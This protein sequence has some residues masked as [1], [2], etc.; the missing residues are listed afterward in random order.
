MEH[1]AISLKAKLASTLVIVPFF[2]YTIL[3]TSIPTL[4]GYL[5]VLVAIAILGFIWSRPG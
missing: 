3:F 1:G 2:A 4:A 5:L